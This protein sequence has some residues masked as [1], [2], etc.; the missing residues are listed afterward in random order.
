VT[1]RAS[2]ATG[3]VTVDLEVTPE[4]GAYFP[5]IELR[6][7]DFVSGY[8]VPA[9]RGLASGTIC[10]SGACRRY[11]AVPAYHDHNWG[12]WRETSW[13]WGQAR[14]ASITALYGGVLTSDT[15]ASSSPFFLALVDGSGVRQVLRFRAVEYEGRRP[16]AGAT[17]A[18]A[19]ERFVIRATSGPDAVVLRVEVIRAQ[20]TRTALGGDRRFFLQMRGA[21]SLDGRLAGVAVSDSGAGFFETFAPE[22]R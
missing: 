17:D 3:A 8:V 20:A 1:G 10:E 5:P 19:P 18:W 9:V 4:P 2:G 12:I 16:V 21:F 15:V 13:E 14:G 7:G 6:S 11:D 22:K